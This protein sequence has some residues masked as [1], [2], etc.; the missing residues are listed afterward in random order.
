VLGTADIPEIAVTSPTAP[1]ITHGWT[2]MTAFTEEVANT[3]LAANSFSSARVV[4]SRMPADDLSKLQHAPRWHAKEKAR[5]RA[6]SPPFK[7]K[8]SPAFVSMSAPI[9][10]VLS[11][12][13]CIVIETMRRPAVVCLDIHADAS[14]SCVNIH[15][16]KRWH[17]CRDNKR[18]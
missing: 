6:F 15:F 7:T 11:P 9:T 17:R 18:A 1:G 12:C 10:V 14:R 4:K 13:R 8:F 5:P 3:R 2:S 16:C